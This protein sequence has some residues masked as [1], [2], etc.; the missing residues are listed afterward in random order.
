MKNKQYITLK[1]LPQYSNK[2][3]LVYYVEELKK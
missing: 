1:E 2:A 3:L